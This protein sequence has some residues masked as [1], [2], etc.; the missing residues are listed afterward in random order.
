MMRDDLKTPALAVLALAFFAFAA[1]L[2]ARHLD[3][4]KKVNAIDAEYFV[5]LEKAFESMGLRLPITSEE[6]RSDGPTPYLSL[7]EGGTIGLSAKFMGPVLIDKSSAYAIENEKPVETVTGLEG[8]V[9]AA[10]KAK[11]GK[12]REISGVNLIHLYFSV[13]GGLVALAG[14]TLQLQAARERKA[15]RGQGN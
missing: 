14:L 10:G 3:N 2:V 7:G 11:L 6:V 9:S 8:A 5:K 4:H 13:V 1:F 12:L 15:K